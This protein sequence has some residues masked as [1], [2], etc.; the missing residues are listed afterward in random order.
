MPYNNNANGL[1]SRT[2]GL[3]KGNNPV[4]QTTCSYISSSFVEYFFIL[5]FGLVSYSIHS[6][7][8]SIKCFIVFTENPKYLTLSLIL[9]FH[10][11]LVSLG[12][13]T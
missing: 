5:S 13:I 7:P 6:Q 10:R 3:V 2:E 11:C 1:A 8:F 12:F 9:L 4:Y